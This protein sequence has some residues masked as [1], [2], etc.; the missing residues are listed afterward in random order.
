M[1]PQPKQVSLHG[2]N[3]LLGTIEPIS[4]SEDSHQEY[5]TT[6]FFFIMRWRQAP[7]FTCKWQLYKEKQPA[8]EAV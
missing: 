4:E 3:V 7:T 5:S 1:C 8:A 2:K 6:P